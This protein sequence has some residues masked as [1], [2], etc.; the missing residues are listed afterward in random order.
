MVLPD[1]GRPHDRHRL[2]R[3]DF[4]ADVLQ[5]LDGPEG[6]MHVPEG[7]FPVHVIVIHRVGPV[8]DEGAGIIDL[9]DLGGRGAETLQIVDESAEVAHRVSQRPGQGGE[10]HQFAGGNL[11]PDDESAPK[12]DGDE[13]HGSWPAAQ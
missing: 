7:D 10:N 3:L 13:G 8:G 5:H 6:E 1:P 11:A 4:K 2:P 9:D 12:E